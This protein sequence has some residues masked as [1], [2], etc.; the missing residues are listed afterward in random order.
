LEQVEK[1]KVVSVYIEDEMKKSYIDYAMSVIVGRA[2]PDVRDGLKPVHRRILFG[3]K[4]RGWT[5]ERPY[6][7]SAKIVGEVIGNY[8]PHGDVAVYDS[9][10]RMVQ[11]FSLRYPL[12]D[13]QGNFGSIDGD[14]PAAYR[15]TEA[16][17]ASI[18]TEMLKDIDKDTVDFTPT[19]DGSMKEP[20]VLPAAIP[21]LLVNGSSGIAVGMATNIPPHNLSEV[22]D[23]LIMMIDDPEVEITELMKII[24][25]PDFPQGAIIFGRQGVKDAYLTG[26]GS[27]KLRAKVDVEEMSASREAII[28]KEMPYQV[29]K[30]QLMET[31]AELVRDKKLEGISDLRDESDRDGTRVVIELKRDANSQIILNQLFSHTQLEVSFGIIMLALVDNNPKVLNLRELLYH[32]IEHRKVV[33]TRRTRYELAKAEARAHILEGLKI[34][35][36]N[37][38]KVIK[39]IRDSDNVE[40]AR[41]ALM[42]NFSL[43]REQAQAILDMKLQQLTGLEREKL[44]QEYLE[45]I[46]RIAMLKAILDDPKKLMAIIKDELLKV[47]EKYGDARRTKIVAQAV[48]MDIEDLIKEE[49]VIVTI[50]HSGYIKRLPATT[51][52]SQHRGGKGV[53]G[54]VTKEED[55]VEDIFVTST[56][57]YML[58]FS[59][60]GRVYWLKVYELPEASRQGKGKAIVNLIQL[61]SQGERISAAIPVRDFNNPD[62]YLLMATKKGVIK[63]TPLT[64][65]SNPR[66]GGIIAINLD[67][68]DNLIGVKVTDGKEE[69]VIGTRKGTAIHF[70]EEEVRPIGRTGMGVRGIKLE[71]GDDVVGMEVVRGKET[72]LTATE[73]GFGKRTGADKYRLQSRGGKGV[74]NIK[75]N[76]RNGLVIGIKRVSDKDDIVLMTSQGI[77]IRQPVKDISVIG[78]NTVGVRL[79]RLEDQDKLV[80]ISRISTEEVEAEIKETEDK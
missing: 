4:E 56:H 6:V 28:V 57:N 63:K 19:F 49:D 45:L 79:I 52:R 38:T 26:R 59:N 78:R 61:S 65:Y 55:F 24:K 50:S 70:K 32:Y 76:E 16:R 66:K 3:M 10:V 58:F 7:K 11:D 62:A 29:N 68:G 15:Y 54:V 77:V 17:L 2:L 72:F 25:A 20:V 34:A 1:E 41:L 73:N 9:M 27:I 75:P 47:K 44:E 46:K 13:G 74:I 33:V 12:I 37:L 40:T 48:E 71:D 23:G 21:N 42:K 8:H 60:L 22:V 36:D 30:A 80:S 69:I 18:A 5:H 53:T 35:L 51:Y 67:D 39:V 64:E 43:S 31:I 14:P